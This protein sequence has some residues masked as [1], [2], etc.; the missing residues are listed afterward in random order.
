MEAGRTIHFKGNTVAIPRPNDKNRRNRALI[1]HSSLE[2][3]DKVMDVTPKVC[4]TSQCVWCGNAFPDGVHLIVCMSCHTCQYCGLVSHRN[5]ACAYCGNILPDEL[6]A[7]STISEI[8]YSVKK[9]VR[10]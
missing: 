10:V 8:V 1:A 7:D 6:K 4:A 9:R 3:P 5:D 2:A